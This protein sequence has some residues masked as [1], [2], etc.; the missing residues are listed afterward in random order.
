VGDAKME[1]YEYVCD[2]FQICQWERQL[3]EDTVNVFRPSST[4]GSIESEGLITSHPST[5]AQ[6]KQYADTL[7]RT[8][9]SWSRTNKQLWAE[10]NVAVDVGLGLI[11]MGIADVGVRYTES[12]AEERVANVLQ[13]LCDASAGPKTASYHYLRGFALYEPE[14]VHV[15]KPLNLRHWTRTAALND[16]DEILTRMMGE[17]GWRV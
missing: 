12:R 7:I 4:P 1:L 2:Y 9:R 11:T 13:E 10:G 15:L 14:R 6:R 5:F 17:G 8:F 16:A 3:I